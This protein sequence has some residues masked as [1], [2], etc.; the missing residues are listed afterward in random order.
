MGG[1]TVTAGQF[2]EMV[3]IGHP[4]DHLASIRSAL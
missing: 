3:L 4:K 2:A 1:Q